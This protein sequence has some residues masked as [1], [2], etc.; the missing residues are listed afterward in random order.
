MFCNTV[1]NGTLRCLPI[2]LDVTAMEGPTWSWKATVLDAV[3]T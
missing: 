3:Q 2:L 1:C